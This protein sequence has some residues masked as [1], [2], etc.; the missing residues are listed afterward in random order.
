VLSGSFSSELIIK[1]IWPFILKITLILT[2]FIILCN[3]CAI[4]K[5]WKIL[6]DGSSYDWDSFIWV[7]LEI[8]LDQ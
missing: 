7:S 5:A 1:C 2:E 8:A 3:F 6:I 4:N